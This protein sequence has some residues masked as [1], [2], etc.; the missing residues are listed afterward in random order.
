MK[1][2]SFR[3][4]L[5]KKVQ[6]DSNLAALL[7]YAREDVLADAVVES[8]EKM[9]RASHKG[10][11]A[12]FAVRRFGTEMDSDTE[13][14]ML[15]DAIGHHVSRYK[16]ALGGGRQDLANR[17]AKQA[18]NLMNMA[19]TAQKHTGGK[20][21]IDYVDPKP[22]ERN[23][24]TNQYGPEHKL[25]QAGKYKPGD[26]TTK[27]KGLRYGL[28]GNDFSFLNQPPHE[29]YSN[30][31][32]R[33]KHNKAYPFEQVRIN[34]KYIPVEDVKDLKGYEEHE[35]DKHPIMQHFH[36]SPND[37][38]PER[39]QEYVASHDKYNNE[40]PHVEN[41]FNR[42]A[43]MESKDPK[44]YGERGSKPADPVHGDVGELE[45]GSEEAPQA[46][47]K[48]S[49]APKAAAGPTE[50]PKGIEEGAWG[51]MSPELQAELARLMGGKK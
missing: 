48:P 16:A 5:L 9:A 31:I 26:F 46:A 49:A 29:S 36:E 15:R 42:H 17:H 22:W 35:F 6:H 28:S 18:F 30:E 3:E 50:R 39:D 14:H 1:L 4:L 10:D 32:K 12:N 45:L 38:T 23:K 47:A 20:M 37:R 51:T 7:K 19:D 21:S 27:T 2:S 11:A 33:H 41:F 44:A 13:P 8:L 43:E 25:V 34:G 40:E 24:Y